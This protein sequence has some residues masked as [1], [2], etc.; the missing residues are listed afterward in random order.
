MWRRQPALP[1]AGLVWEG[2]HSQGTCRGPSSNCKHCEQQQHC[3]AS[4]PA[5]QHRRKAAE[6]LRQIEVLTKAGLH[7]NARDQERGAKEYILKKAKD[8]GRAWQMFYRHQ[9][10]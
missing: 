5:F 10:Q 7:G 2:R 1:L 4:P 3:P 8:T 6:A 9:E